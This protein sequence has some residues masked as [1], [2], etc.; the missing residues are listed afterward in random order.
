MLGFMFQNHGAYGL[1]IYIYIYIWY[2]IWCIYI[3]MVKYGV[4]IYIY[5]CSKKW[6]NMV[7]I[8]I[9]IYI[10]IYIYISHGDLRDHIQN[11]PLELTLSPGT[12][13]VPEVL[14]LALKA[15]LPAEYSDAQVTTSWRS[16]LVG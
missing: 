4:Y 16:T 2:I 11:V 10:Y 5:I 9:Y 1:C 12:H 13:E 7:Y 6:Y 14:A 15:A 3:Y 8:I